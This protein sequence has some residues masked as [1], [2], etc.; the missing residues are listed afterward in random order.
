MSQKLILTLTACSLVALSTACSPLSDN[1]YDS[2]G[3]IGSRADTTEDI[4]AAK[5]SWTMVEDREMAGDPVNLHSTARK[6]VN[7]SNKTKRQFI[8]KERLANVRGAKGQEDVHFRLVRIER[9]VNEL[10]ND[11]DKLLPPLS[12]LIVA[13]KELDQTIAEITARPKHKPPVPNMPVYNDT[14]TPSETLLDS[15]KT[16]KA[17]VALKPLGQ[18]ARA[19]ATAQND[20]PAK[21]KPQMAAAPAPTQGGSVVKNIRL[22][23]HPGK[24]RLV[25]DLTGETKYRMDLDND[26]HLLLIELSDA[27]WSAAGQKLM[28]HP[29]IKGYTTQ[30]SPDGGTILALE[31]KKS[32]KIIGSSALRPNSKY[33]NRI[34]LDLAATT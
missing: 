3:A 22:G 30:K 21:A 24:T 9:Q 34:Y 10:R 18:T 1:S 5:G 28:N 31:L 26:E 14:G 23:E 11:F 27:G 8:P 2:A 33:G 12:D 20:S 32:A 15:T 17:P 19:P 16:A 4:L 13:D 6:Q 29:L 7:P 25:L